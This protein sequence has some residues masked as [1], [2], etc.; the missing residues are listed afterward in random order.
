M[1]RRRK[2][3]PGTGVSVWVQPR[4]PNCDED[5]FLHRLSTCGLRIELVY[6]RSSE[7]SLARSKHLMNSSYY[8]YC[9]CGNYYLALYITIYPPQQP[10][11]IMGV[12][13]LTDVGSTHL[14]P[15]STLQT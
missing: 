6:I 15:V 3:V 8:C 2:V 14:S 4:V 13:H 5:R 1:W 10:P 12:A 11:H 9:Y 7:Q